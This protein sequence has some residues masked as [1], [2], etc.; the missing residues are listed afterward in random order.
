MAKYQV[1]FFEKKNGDVPAEEFINS[2]DVKMSAKIY[3][4]LTMIS[5][6]TPPAE[7][8]KAKAYREESRKREESNQ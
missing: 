5:E 4:L 6:K 7:I 2:L 3:R 1:A 8:D